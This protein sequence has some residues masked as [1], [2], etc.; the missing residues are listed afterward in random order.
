MSITRVGVV[1]QGREEKLRL[2]AAAVAAAGGTVE[3]VRWTSDPERDAVRFDALVLCG[4]DDSDA[5]LWGE[6][7]H[8]SR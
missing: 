7:N 4:G 6:E 2:Y 5:R 8:L 3:V 1:D